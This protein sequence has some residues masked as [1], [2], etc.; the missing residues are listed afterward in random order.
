[1]DAPSYA[2]D[3]AG[4]ADLVKSAVASGASALD[5]WQ[6]KRVFAAYG[7]PVP[8]G[9]LA[10]SQSEAVA[11]AERIGGKVVMKGIGA[12]IHH[13]TEAG[14]VVLGVEGPEEVA[15]TYELLEQRAAGA[16]EAVLVEQMVAGNRELM[17]GMKRDPA[18]GPVLAFGLGGILTEVLGD[19][20]LALIP[21]SERDV[22]QLPD[23]IRSKRILGPFRGFP[24]V[25]RKALA[26][27]MT[28]L[29]QMALDF[30]EIAEIDVNPLLIEGDQPVAADAL[31]ILSSETPQ[32]PQRSSFVPN[33][34]A[35]VAPRSMAV[36]G[37]S[38][39]ITKWGGS[40]LRNII[41]GGYEGKI[42][43][44]NPK[45]GEFFGLQSYAS[46]EELPETPDLALL[47]VGGHQVGPMLEQCARKGIP[48]AIAI[49]AGFSETGTTGAD[50]EREIARIASEGGVTLMGPNCMGMISNEVQLHA[51][52]FVVLHPPKGTLTFVSQSGNIGV[53]T[54]SYCQRRGIGID[55]FLSV[56]NEA[57]IGV[58][59]A[60]DYLRDDPNTACIM[61]YVEGIDDGRRFLDVARKTSAVK[62]VVVLRTG[63]TEYGSRAAA[64]HTGAM[65]GSA[66]VWEAAARQ[67]GIVTC[68]T[69]VGVVD[70]GTCLAYNPLPK[71]RRVAVVT[72]GGGA[73][74]MAADEV[75]RN[76]LTLAEFPPELYAA[77]DEIL[78]PFWSKHNP[79]DMV[80]SA[81]GDVGPR[82]LKL[83]AECDAVDAI[84]ILSVLGIPTSGSEVR[85]M[86]DDG[87]YAG[88]SPWE[89][90]LVDVVAELMQ[91][92]GK[93]IINVPDTP[94]RGSVFDRGKR[95]H[96][97]V[98]ASPQAAARA[99]DRMEWY[100]AQ[101][102]DRNPLF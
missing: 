6:S 62:P 74:V 47:A 22:A 87:E 44:V 21:P 40:A 75:A 14:L 96:P 24:P 68:T 37:A 99:L 12:D 11:A 71:G 5:E 92:T 98:L 36:V 4:A 54:T 34:K 49:A 72:N 84:I 79:L 27:I 77:L 26:A 46:L 42:Y 82:V 15:K 23:L 29:S 52:G 3:L 41:Q 32:G 1:M 20:A 88:L 60:L 76:G 58:V 50:A 43:P 25:D 35:L 93:P 39:D 65:A 10:K 18:F 55:K 101:R 16:L 97:I 83:V 89:T 7:I 30:P 102:R 78:P 57:Q 63:L 8:A 94:I 53:Q 69:S 17:V 81:G 38:G 100:A 85:P 19:I 13:K 61:M 56:G 80:A 73:G 90:A 51:V 86:T 95:Y 67:A 59:E 33:M 45:G 9:A 66:A 48:A 70:L 31:V 28:A 91:A 2:L 64:S